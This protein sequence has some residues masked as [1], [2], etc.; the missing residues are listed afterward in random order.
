[1]CTVSSH[2]RTLSL[3]S[4]SKTFIGPVVVSFWFA[5]ISRRRDF[6]KIQQE[7]ASYA[8]FKL[9]QERDLWLRHDDD[10]DDDDDDGMA[11]A[12]DNGEKQ[13]TLAQVFHGGNR[14]LHMWKML[15]QVVQ[16]EPVLERTSPHKTRTEVYATAMK[17][18]TRV[19]SLV[20]E[21]KLNESDA[22]ILRILVGE[23][24]PTELHHVM[25]MP[26]IHALGSDEQRQKWL[27]RARAYEIIGTYAQTEMGHGSDVQGIETTATYDPKTDEWVLHTPCMSAT[28]WWPG[29][30]G[31]TAT[32]AVVIARLITRGKD[33]GP[34]PFCVELRSPTTHQPVRGVETWDIGPKMGYNTMDNGAMRLN[35]LR[36]PRDAL[37]S[38]YHS[39]ARGGAYTA[40]PHAKLG[41]AAMTYTRCAIV[42][43][44]ALCLGA[45]CAIAVRY[46]L[47][48]RQFRRNGGKEVLLLDYRLHQSRLLPLVATC[49]AFSVASQ[50]LRER[51]DE[52]TAELERGDQK[53]LQELHIL[54]S[55]LKA[56]TTRVAADGIEECRKCCG[57]NGY[58][59][60]SGI[61]T[62]LS[63]YLPSCTYEG[64]NMVLHQQVARVLIKVKGKRGISRSAIPRSY[65]YLASDANGITNSAFMPSNSAATTSSPADIDWLVAVFRRRASFLVDAAR[66]CVDAAG[67]GD[68]GED[69]AC[70]HLQRASIAHNELL[71]LELFA[72]RIGQETPHL[73]SDASST[74]RHL[75]VLYA[76]NIVSN[77]SSSD[78]LESGCF[79][80]P[81]Q[82]DACRGEFVRT[83]TLVRPLA[84]SLIDDFSFS[85]HFLNSA[86][87]S[88]GGTRTDSADAVY[89][90]LFG[91]LS[92]NPMNAP[93]RADIAR[94][95][96]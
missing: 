37:L 10:D 59:V 36:V 70:N 52:V 25:F 49:F 32:H 83:L 15:S 90:R 58:L 38:R 61:P 33:F 29:S 22:A 14:G 39:V 13:S 48:R 66:I 8:F 81:A 91:T 60:A 9:Q 45:G 27:Q 68:A 67:G 63:D 77:T 88:P 51:Y 28:K 86:L 85:D 62:L 7:R 17:K 54:T 26:V 74:L 44:A 31:R 71:V 3:V 56:L 65:S 96:L 16:R 46:A 47:V 18:A 5:R 92:S 2:S 41:Y 84:A 87:V 55:G 42:S 73:S 93:D 34:H 35:N 64:D 79:S 11:R 75:A 20:K 19:A 80:S 24:L 43:G 23:T 69:A 6:F 21:L 95:R 30:L 57:G 40:P 4:I 1:M 76:L 53:S 50:A 12:P 78:F 82:L 72:R 94:P 89:T